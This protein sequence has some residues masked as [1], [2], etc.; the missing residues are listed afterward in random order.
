MCSGEMTGPSFAP[1]LTNWNELAPVSRIGHRGQPDSQAGRAETHG[2]FVRSGWRPSLL[3][4]RPLLAGVH[5][6]A[7]GKGKD[8]VRILPGSSCSQQEVKSNMLSKSSFAALGFD[9]TQVNC[10][11]SLLHLFEEAQDVF[12]GNVARSIA[13]NP[14]DSRHLT[15]RD[16]SKHK[17]KNATRNKCIASSN[18]CLTSSNK[19]ATRSS[20]ASLLGAIGRYE[21]GS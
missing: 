1:L 16:D 8:T 10:R 19:N 14:R 5:P 6:G 2:C 15:T 17:S 11:Q 13:I 18:K 7:K 12:N 4:W 20:R 9:T 21:R 3:G